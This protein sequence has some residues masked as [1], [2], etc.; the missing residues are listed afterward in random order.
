MRLFLSIVG[1]CAL[2]V[3]TVVVAGNGMAKWDT[4]KSDLIRCQDAATF[5]HPACGSTTTGT[6]PLQEGQVTMD[7]DDV[8]VKVDK[9]LPNTTYRVAFVSLTNTGTDVAGPYTAQ[10]FTVGEL[11]TN[12]RGNG[13]E[14]FRNLGFSGPTL[15]YFVVY[16]PDVSNE[17]VTGVDPKVPPVASPSPSAPAPYGPY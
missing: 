2:L 15:G 1:L 16:H 7:R 13:N 17:F 12:R 10:V 9:A 5:G 6:D 14:K 4:F 11:N 3:A 8:R